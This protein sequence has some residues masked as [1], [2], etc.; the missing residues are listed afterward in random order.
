VV[1]DGA[2]SGNHGPEM[3]AAILDYGA[4]NL[5][6]LAK[7]LNR[8]GADTV[9]TSDAESALTADALILPGV[10]AF[11]LAAEAIAGQM[12]EVRA[13]LIDGLPC[14]GICLGMQLLFESSEEGEGEGVG[15]FAGR[16]RKLSGR[17]VPQIGWNDLEETEGEL[18]DSS[19][20]R[21]AYFANSFICEPSDTSTVRAWATHENERF[22]AAVE[23]ANVVGVQFHPEKSSDR[24]IAFI[25]EFLRRVSK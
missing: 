2:D 20:L 10:G 4:G 14:L 6:S 18:F 22:A 12:S 24:G 23:T 17:R 7:A 21:T 8:A 19:K 3:K 11:A 1:D 25:A 15:V 5:H 16:V 9:I 13:A